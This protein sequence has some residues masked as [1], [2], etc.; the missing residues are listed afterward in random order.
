MTYLIDSKTNL[1]QNTKLYLSTAIRGKWISATMYR[2]IEKL[3][4]MI[5]RNTSLQ[6]VE[7]I[8]QTRNGLLVSRSSAYQ[9][10]QPWAC[11]R[12]CGAG[13]SQTSSN[14]AICPI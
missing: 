8:Y 10:W 4:S 12:A 14:T 1:C 5:N 7:K 2:D 9:A 13:L 6:R 3:F 11:A